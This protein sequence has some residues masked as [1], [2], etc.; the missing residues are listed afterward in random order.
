MHR[1]I[2]TAVDKQ[3]LEAELTPKR[4]VRQFQ[5]LSV[6]MITA[7]N[8]PNVMDEIGRIREIEFRREGGGT[9][10]EKDVDQFDTGEI[11]Y[12]QLVAWDPKEREIVAMYRY[13]LCRNAIRRDGEISLATHRLFS[14]SERFIEEILPV[15]I[16]LGRSVVNRNAK[17]CFHGLYVIWAGLAA[18][19]NEYGEM[20]YFF[21]KTT[22]Y[23][24]CPAMARDML[25]S[26]IELYFGDNG[27]LV[28]PRENLRYEMTSDQAKL[29]YLF[30]GNDYRKDY[31]KLLTEYSKLGLSVP[32][33]IISYLRLTSTIKFFGTAWNPHF[34]NVMET[35]FLLTIKDINR[36]KRKK[37]IDTYKSINPDLFF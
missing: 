25:F 1:D 29:S 22:I 2:I 14:F 30:S 9:A 16:E 7:Q 5:G 32:P 27:S 4:L 17:K 28:K 33:L 31:A 20:R 34:G 18:L 36:S 24:S 21:G 6:Y 11:P 23:E 8:A 3:A 10:K 26:F 13:I 37:F 12:R 19:V 35:A 15:T